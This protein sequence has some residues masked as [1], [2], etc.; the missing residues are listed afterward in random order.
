M[1]NAN[2]DAVKE[3]A[4]YFGSMSSSPRAHELLLRVAERSDAAAEQARICL[5]WHPESEDLSH[6]GA[7]LIAPGDPD[8][9]GTDRSGLA[10]F[11]VKAYGDN[12][13]PY[14]ER[15]VAGSPYVW[16]RVES[17]Q[18]LALHDRPIGFQFLL[19]QLV[20][21]PWSANHAHKPQLIRWVRDNFLSEL[22]RDASDDLVTSFLRSRLAELSQKQ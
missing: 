7:V 16:V 5:T 8:P 21:Q 10:Y 3:L 1:A 14:L 2:I 19:D 6:L 4:E 11:L 12:A 17:A 9:H 20:Q 22:P 13:L 18:Q 15:A